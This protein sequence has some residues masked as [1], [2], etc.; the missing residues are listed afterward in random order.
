[1]ERYITML[2]DL[3]EKLFIANTPRMIESWVSEANAVFKELQEN[4]READ[5]YDVIKTAEMQ[6]EQLLSAD[7]TRKKI[8]E[9]ITDISGLVFEKAKKAKAMNAFETLYD[10]NRD[11]VVEV[12]KQLL[13]ALS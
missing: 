11:A 1:M 3:K 4:F 2:D 10:K 6:S 9:T 13:D 8:A 12:L 7:C 5:I